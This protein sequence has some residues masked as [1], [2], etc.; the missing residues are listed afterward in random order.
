MLGGKR[1]EK[2]GNFFEPTIMEITDLS[3]ILFKEE[4]FGPVLP[5]FK[6]KNDLEAV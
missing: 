3:N 6:V 1:M 5:L 2:K 4:V